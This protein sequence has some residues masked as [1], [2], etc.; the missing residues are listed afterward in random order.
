VDMVL[1]DR[2]VDDPHPQ[3]FLRDAECLAHDAIAT[4]A[5]Q[6]RATRDDTAGDVD[7]VAPVQ[8]SPARM[9]NLRGRPSG[10]AAGAAA[11]AAP[12]AREHELE[13]TSASCFR[14]RVHV[15]PA[16]ARSRRR[17]SLETADMAR[18]GLKR[19]TSPAPAG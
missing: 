9:R 13:L 19:R 17:T 14:H 4:G 6:V 1:L 16:R 12:R 15:G 2:E 10:L 8:P 7:R 5:S 3:P 18:R 11:L